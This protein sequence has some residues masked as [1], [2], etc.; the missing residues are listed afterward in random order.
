MECII[1]ILSIINEYYKMRLAERTEQ[2]LRQV[3]KIVI[4][5]FIYI[6]L[7]FFSFKF[8]INF[9]RKA[10]LSFIQKL[11]EICNRSCPVPLLILTDFTLLVYLYHCIYEPKFNVCRL[12]VKQYVKMRSRVFQEKNLRIDNRYA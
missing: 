1:P 5:F 4:F 11:M 9:F 12:N 2:A 7:L 6:H 8:V 3:L 10:N